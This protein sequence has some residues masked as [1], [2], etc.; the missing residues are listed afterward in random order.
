MGGKDGKEAAVPLPPTTSFM[1]ESEDEE[2]E[3]P[4]GLGN[5][6]LPSNIFKVY[7]IKTCSL[8]KCSSGRDHNELYCV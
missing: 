2:E 8:R 1:E 3:G 7:M 6:E 5:V 4:P